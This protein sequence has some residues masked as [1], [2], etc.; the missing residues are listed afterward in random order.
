MITLI[1]IITIKSSFPC[2]N[3]L[4]Y[5]QSNKIMHL[6]INPIKV[7]QTILKKVTRIYLNT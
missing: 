2:S 3:Q 1:K 5:S 7:Y 6:G 4:G